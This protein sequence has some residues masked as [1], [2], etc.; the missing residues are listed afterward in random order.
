[1]KGRGQKGLFSTLVDTMGLEAEHRRQPASRMNHLFLGRRDARLE[2][3]KWVFP[4]EMGDGEREGRLCEHRPSEMKRSLA[5]SLCR[6]AWSEEGGLRKK[7]YIKGMKD[8][9]SK[10]HEFWVMQGCQERGHRGK[11]RRTE[12]VYIE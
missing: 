1:M 2:T 10:V 8:V 6:A 4:Q 7:G 9:S 11:C 3:V 5:G 12:S